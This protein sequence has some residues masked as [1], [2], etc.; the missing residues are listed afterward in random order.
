MCT[1][2]GGETERER[3]RN[4]RERGRNRDIHN[5]VGG[6]QL[7]LTIVHHT[8]FLVNPSFTEF[9]GARTLNLAPLSSKQRAAA[10][11]TAKVMH[12]R[13]S[14]GRQF[15]DHS[16]S[17][18]ALM[19][20]GRVTA[21]V[22][23]SVSRSGE[24]EFSKT[25]AIA[26]QLARPNFVQVELSA[27]RWRIARW[28]VLQRCLRLPRKPSRSGSTSGGRCPYWIMV[29]GQQRSQHGRRLFSL[30]AWGLDVSFIGLSYRV[31][32]FASLVVEKDIGQ[33]LSETSVEGRVVLV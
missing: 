28:W 25:A 9:G 7:K 1:C 32:P 5:R 19:Q 2:G 29:G 31:H 11:Q 8:C 18:W 14:L 23:T 10:G 16:K 13:F 26:G 4:R 20:R 3:R 24:R 12:A 33:N 27:W 30:L 6:I 15:L 21:S 17:R 22:T